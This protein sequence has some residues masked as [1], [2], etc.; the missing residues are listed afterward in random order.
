MVRR[1]QV[2]YKFCI[3]VILLI[4]S[5]QFTHTSTAN[6]AEEEEVEA[7][8]GNILSF[9]D[10]NSMEVWVTVDSCRIERRL[11]LRRS[12]RT[13]GQPGLNI[14]TIFLSAIEDVR[15]NDVRGET[16][17]T[18]IPK[19]SYH[20]ALAPLRYTGQEESWYCDGT[21]A[22]MS[23]L[24]VSAIVIPAG[25]EGGATDLLREYIID[26]CGEKY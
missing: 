23:N 21:Y 12:C 7:Q 9:K 22:G 24:E 8:L 17:I 10:S 3:G 5:I 14:R 1:T 19:D 15:S 11:V 2:F 26:Y 16:V 20:D 4:A 13:I 18:F 25:R 6:H